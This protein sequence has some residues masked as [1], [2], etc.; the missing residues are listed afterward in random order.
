MLCLLCFLIGT[1][2][3]VS[4]HAEDI[5]KEQKL[6]LAY[7][8]AYNHSDFSKLNRFYNRETVFNDRTAK[9]KYTGRYKIVNFLQR[10]RAGVLETKVQ[11]E[12]MFNQGSLVVI[13]GSHYYR[14]PGE[15]F[16]KPGKMIELAIP[17]VTT[18]SVDTG[19]QQIK[20]HV[21]LLDY[22]TMKDQL[23]TQ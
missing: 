2:F 22:E 23:V 9:R 5:P 10:A 18:L 8:D 7:L 1:A 3:A 19:S 12:H 11:V 16:G 20:E 4:T 15:Q 13:I 6:A 14:G 17:G 21:D